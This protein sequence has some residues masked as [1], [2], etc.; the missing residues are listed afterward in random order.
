MAEGWK[1][2][3]AEV[4]EIDQAELTR[5]LILVDI[6]N[7]DS[8]VALTVMVILSDETGTPVTPREMENLMTFGDIEHLVSTNR[9]RKTLMQEH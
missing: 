4:L 5:D 1:T 3:I 9:Q 2:E 8:A 6:E 7:W